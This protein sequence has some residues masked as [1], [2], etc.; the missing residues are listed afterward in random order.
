M[1]KS[2][3][4]VLC[5]SFVDV[6]LICAWLLAREEDVITLMPSLYDLHNLPEWYHPRLRAPSKEID[7]E[8]YGLARRRI[9]LAD[10]VFVIN[11]RHHVGHD[12]KQEIEYAGTTGKPI[13]W[14]TKDPI[15]E[16]VVKNILAWLKRAGAVHPP[17]CR[18]CGCT[19]E[20]A[21]PGGCFWVEEDL[22]STCASG[23][24]P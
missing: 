12:M 23:V 15:G 18:Q 4:V 8:V 22:C 11:Y 6:T 24:T 7:E 13:R 5:G 9:D 19:E 21:C 20:L 16:A 14:F 1:N 2:K 10:E 17:I 3:V